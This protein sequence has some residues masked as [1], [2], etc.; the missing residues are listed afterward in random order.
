VTRKRENAKRSVSARFARE[1][2]AISIGAW[3]N[4]D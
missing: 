4:R 2:T 3:I 1:S